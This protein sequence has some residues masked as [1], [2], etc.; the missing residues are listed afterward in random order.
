MI[1]AREIMNKNVESVSEHE[2][3]D[4]AAKR[5]RD[6]DIGALMVTGKDGSLRGMLTDRDIVTGCIASGHDPAKCTVSTLAK[7]MPVVVEVGAGVD[8]VLA[9]MGGHRVRRVPVTDNGTLV[10]VIGI[11]DLVDSAGH[12]RI[13]AVMA[14]IVAV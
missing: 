8:E 5:M 6:G 14:K 10:G 1:A 11:G 2:T 7:D 4:V 9:T 13:G 3:V 12:D